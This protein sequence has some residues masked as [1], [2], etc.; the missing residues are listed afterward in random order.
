[1]LKCIGRLVVVFGSLTLFA[2]TVISAHN[3][4]ETAE[5]KRAM[6]ATAPH[7][8][9][10]ARALIAQLRTENDAHPAPQAIQL[11]DVWN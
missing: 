7:S 6:C 11:I 10:E 8:A 3:L 9:D 2:A 4:R 1:M 5:H